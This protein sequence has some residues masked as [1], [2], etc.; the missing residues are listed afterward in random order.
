MRQHQEG[1]EMKGGPGALRY[2]VL[3]PE[4]GNGRMMESGE[5]VSIECPSKREGEE[6]GVWWMRSSKRQRGKKQR[7]LS[8]FLKYLVGEE[9]RDN[10]DTVNQSRQIRHTC[11]VQAVCIP[12]VWYRVVDVKQDSKE[13]YQRSPPLLG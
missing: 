10:Q 7:S 2:G 12:G 13:Q 8:L 4:K 1:S 3:P 9:T 11:L 6:R 5:N